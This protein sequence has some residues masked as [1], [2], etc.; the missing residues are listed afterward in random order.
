MSGSVVGC[1]VV[2][3]VLLGGLIAF[4][5]LVS[6]DIFIP[7][8]GAFRAVLLDRMET[9]LVVGAGLTSSRGLDVFCMLHVSK[10]YYQMYQVDQYS[11]VIR[12][13]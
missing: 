2:V 9:F 13:R 4:C 6:W 10:K 1:C 8:L 7:A 3:L 5:A 11:E 12:D